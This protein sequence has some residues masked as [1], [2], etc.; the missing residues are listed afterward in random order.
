MNKTKQ[1]KTK[2]NKTKQNKTKHSLL[3]RYGLTSAAAL[4]L[5]FGGVSA[6]RADIQDD[7]NKAKTKAKEELFQKLTE[8]L[9][10]IEANEIPT[11]G[12]NGDDMKKLLK[13]LEERDKAEDEWRTKLLQ[14][15]QSRTFDGLDGRDGE[16]GETG[17]R[18]PTGP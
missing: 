1:N 5:T 17:D 10:R 14:G 7:P 6:V 3:C 12:N 4:L 8:V 9:G 15:M 2:Q 18:G 13:Y 16:K 11:P